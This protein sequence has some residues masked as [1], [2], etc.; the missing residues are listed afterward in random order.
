MLKKT[1]IDIIVTMTLVACS[2][3]SQASEASRAFEEYVGRYLEY[4]WETHPEESSG[5]GIYDYRFS[6][7]AMSRQDFSNRSARLSDFL[8]KLESFEQAGFSKD[9]RVDVHLLRSDMLVRRA[10]IEKVRNWERN[11]TMYIP[12]AGLNDLMTGEFGTHRQRTEALLSRLRQVPR[13]LNEGKQNLK[14]PPRVFT[15][16][17]IR[18]AERL[19]P[20]F[21]ENVPDFAARDPALEDQ[22]NTA[23]ESAKAAL[24]DY[25]EF[26]KDDL[27]QRS[28]GSISIGKETYDFYLKEWHMLDDDSDSLL[29]KG[30]RY[31]RDTEQLL[32]DAARDIDPAKTWQEITEDIRQHHPDSEGLLDAYC[33]EIQRSKQHIIEHDLVTMPA[34][35]EVRC[36]YTP[37]S[38]RAFSPFG[39][40]R[41]PAPFSSSKIGFLILHP[42]DESL[43]LDDQEKML[44]AHDFTW[45]SVIAPHESYPGHH[46]Q[47][48][49]AQENPR[50]FRR[51]YES[52]I[53][54]EGWGLY[55]EELMYET[56]FFK[57]EKLTRL[58]QLR[59]RLWRAAR[60]I[61]D[62]KLHT[63]QITY[64]EARQFLIDKVGF[65]A[66]S[67]AGEVNI[68]IFR[69]GYAISYVVGFDQIMQLRDDYKRRKGDEFEL[70]EFHDR[71]LTQGAMPFPLVRQLLLGE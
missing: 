25:I 40:F 54:S 43:S 42:I 44:R 68:Y 60:I 34:K 38:Q 17:A 41:Q 52:P 19:V 20:F 7:A 10:K 48:L 12:F 69:P 49:K 26:L 63:G 11:P 57:Q 45:I 39:T 51:I 4:L 30:E 6:L 14:R 58:T 21:E 47:A 22:M 15:E 16:T 32:D 55:C 67:T 64:D 37:P 70:R 59:L 56:G 1:I 71:L 23:A 8:Q 65:E 53:F 5:Q 35:E 61:L 62:T 31:F 9:Q 3:A 28:D 50:L 36:L 27:L 13:V 24:L 46:V 2:T 33:D 66:S 29:Q 18:T